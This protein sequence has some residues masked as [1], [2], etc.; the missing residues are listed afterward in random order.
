[1]WRDLWAKH[2]GGLVG[3]AAGLFFGIIYLLS[4]FWD[5]LVVAFIMLVCWLI[6][7]KYD[8]NGTVLDIENWIGWLT[9]RWRRFK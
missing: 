1:M 7:K 9:E 5:M 2:K 8:E 3:L 6:G 4:G